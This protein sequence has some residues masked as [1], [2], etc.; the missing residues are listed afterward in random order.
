MGGFNATSNVQAAM[1][2]NITAVGTMAHAYILSFTKPL[3]ETA[4]EQKDLV[5]EQLK[6]ATF[7]EFANLILKWKDALFNSAITP[8]NQQIR[9][10]NVQ[11]SLPVLSSYRGNANELAAFATF[12]FTQP[13]NFTALVDTYDTLN[14]GLPNYILVACALMEYGV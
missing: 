13:T 3:E 12:A 1:N 8:F 5:S 11:N 4:I 10:D 9:S 7:T 6:G 2:L 14:S